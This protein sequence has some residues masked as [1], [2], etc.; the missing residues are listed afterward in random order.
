LTIET[1]IKQASSLVK[2]PEACLD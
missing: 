2:S 1:L